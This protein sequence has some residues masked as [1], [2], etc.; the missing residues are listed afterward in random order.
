MGL[1]II[2]VTWAQDA[3]HDSVI[4]WHFEGKLHSI[5]WR[6]VV[7]MEKNRESKSIMDFEPGNEKTIVPL[8]E[9]LEKEAS[10]VLG[11]NLT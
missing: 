2:A 11:K 1:A 3:E 6:T 8:I 9:R 5:L 4:V 10:L 7:E